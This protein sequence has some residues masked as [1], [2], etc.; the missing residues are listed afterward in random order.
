MR[1]FKSKWVPAF[2]AIS[3]VFAQCKNNQT[4]QES[5]EIFIKNLSLRLSQCS[6]KIDTIDAIKFFTEQNKI[7]E[8]LKAYLFVGDVYAE[9]NENAK[10]IDY[11]KKA[12][13]KDTAAIMPIYDLGITF[14][15]ENLLDSSILYLD[16]ALNKKIVG[17]FFV[18]YSKIEF[19]NNT[20][21]SEFDVSSNEIIYHLGLSYYYRRNLKQALSCFDFLVTN[22]YRIG[23]ILI[24]RGAIFWENKKVKE[25]CADF[26][27]AKELGNPEASDFI[28]KY[29]LQ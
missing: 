15:D 23:D 26:Q 14:Y 13:K 16:K 17:D 6:S 10:A 11:Y 25:A 24:Y 8:C 21:E 18:D 5:C 9:I 3:L 2:F 7:E 4:T 1:N 29:C 12:L 27:R 22:N 20:T 19:K 28:K